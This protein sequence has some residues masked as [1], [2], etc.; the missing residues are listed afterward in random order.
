MSRSMSCLVPVPEY[1]RKQRADGI[2]LIAAKHMIVCE[3]SDSSCGGVFSPAGRYGLLHQSLNARFERLL[4]FDEVIRVIRLKA[5]AVYWHAHT[6]I[7]PIVR[8]NVWYGTTLMR[9]KG[10]PG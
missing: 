8:S 6:Y 1:L 2:V 4:A 9:M 5:R 10:L 3:C 7:A